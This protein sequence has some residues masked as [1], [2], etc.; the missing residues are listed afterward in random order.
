[1]NVVGLVMKE[2]LRPKAR[3]LS[4]A[5][6]VW[7]LV[8]ILSLIAIGFLVAGVFL[9]LSEPLGAG[10]AA[11]LTGGILIVLAIIAVMGLEIAQRRAAKT[12][13]PDL[14]VLIAAGVLAG[15]AGFTEQK[16]DEKKDD[17]A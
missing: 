4:Y 2:L 16:L 1:M 5:L 8:A 17:E 15:L 14:V 13:T 11:L 9:L 6:A 12:H 7:G 10:G 3:Q